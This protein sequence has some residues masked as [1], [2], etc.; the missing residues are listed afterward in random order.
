MMT[1]KYIKRKWK[2]DSC[3]FFKTS[4][5]TKGHNSVMTESMA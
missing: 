5:Q 1:R 2:E 4:K 3:D